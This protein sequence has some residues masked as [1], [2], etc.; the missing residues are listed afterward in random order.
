ME[1]EFG[2]ERSSTSE[3]RENN[4]GLTL[5]AKSERNVWREAEMGQK[6]RTILGC[7]F[8]ENVDHY[9]S[10]LAHGFVSAVSLPSGEMV[11]EP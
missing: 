6:A 8:I 5:T 2:A 7:F 10:I 9:R 4:L 1:L 11:G 3:T